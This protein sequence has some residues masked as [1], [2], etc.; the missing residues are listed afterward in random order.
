MRAEGNDRLSVEV[1]AF[2]ESI[3]DHRK[4][5]PPDREADKD[6]VILR[7]ICIAIR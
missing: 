1:I 5:S 7:N 6:G 3:A 2:Q 4:I